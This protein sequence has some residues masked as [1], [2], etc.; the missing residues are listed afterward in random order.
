MTI[1]APLI[2]NKD[3]PLGSEDRP[4]E[5]PTLTLRSTVP[6][7]LAILTLA[8]SVIHFAGAAA[9][10]QQYWLFGVVTLIAAWLQVLWALAVV[11]Q[12]SRLLWW[13]VGAILNSGI[14]VV[15]I[16]TR[17]MAGVSGFGV[18]VSV[19]FQALAVVLCLWLVL[20]KRDYAIGRDGRMATY[21]GVGLVT[22]TVLSISLVAG[23][24]QPVTA[25]SASAPLPAVDRHGLQANVPLPGGVSFAGVRQTTRVPD[26]QYHSNI[27]V[28]T[29]GWTVRGTKATSVESFYA[30]HLSKQGWTNVRWE[31][32][33]GGYGQ[34]N[35]LTACQSGQVLLISTSATKLDALDATTGRVTATVTAPHGGAAL[36]IEI[37]KSPQVA[38]VACPSSR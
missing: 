31:P 26:M 38:Q 28:D 21:G 7:C 13:Q 18:A 2:H 11:I 4:L 1:D 12:P 37:D 6:Y 5:T 30:G 16:V 32:A 19:G 8:P 3:R 22:A 29:W 36:L 25:A 35:H 9:H 23:G 10:F 14:I 17:M 33:M 20:S 15:D 24:P 27:S 34:A